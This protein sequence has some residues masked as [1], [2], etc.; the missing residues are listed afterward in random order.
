MNCGVT[1]SLVPR[2]FEGRRKGMGTRLV[3]NSKAV[4]A[5]KAGKAIALPLFELLVHLE[6]I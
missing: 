3:T 4:G 2:P 5:C 1:N 6:N